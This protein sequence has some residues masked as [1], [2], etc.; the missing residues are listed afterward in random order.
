MYKVDDSMTTAEKVASVRAYYHKLLRDKAPRDARIAEL[1]PLAAEH[2]QLVAERD[3]QGG[4]WG[5]ECTENVLGM[6]LVRL[7]KER[8]ESLNE[9]LPPSMH[10]PPP[11]SLVD[12]D[13][14]LTGLGTFHNVDR[15][16]YVHGSDRAYLQQMQSTLNEA[17]NDAMKRAALHGMGQLRV[18]THDRV[19]QLRNAQPSALTVPEQVTKVMQE[20]VCPHTRRFPDSGACVACGEPRLTGEPG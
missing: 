8:F 1:E 12:V 9:W 14:R 3:N 6:F 11:G 18:A 7:E 5:V 15:G 19:E 20:V 16:D 13:R 2:A 4:R 17:H 10:C